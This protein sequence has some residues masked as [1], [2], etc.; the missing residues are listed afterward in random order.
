MWKLHDWITV[1]EEKFITVNVLDK[2]NDTQINLTFD[3]DIRA[4]FSLRDQR[5][6]T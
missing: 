3:F 6:S 5:L 2:K 1:V 4:I